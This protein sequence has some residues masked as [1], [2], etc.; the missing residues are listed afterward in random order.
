[1]FQFPQDVFWGEFIQATAIVILQ[2]SQL[3]EHIELK[4]QINVGFRGFCLMRDTFLKV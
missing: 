1:M 2:T 4:L 3:K